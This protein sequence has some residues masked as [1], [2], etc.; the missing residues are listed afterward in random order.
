[1]DRR[2]NELPGVQSD[3][4]QRAASLTHQLP[5]ADGQMITAISPPRGTDR[6]NKRFD[7]GSQHSSSSA[8]MSD[9][10]DRPRNPPPQT[11]SDAFLAA[12]LGSGPIVPTAQVHAPLAANLWAGS[13]AGD[14]GA[15]P[16]VF[17][18]APIASSSAP[19][20]RRNLRYA[21]SNCA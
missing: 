3:R 9:Q 4:S 14:T 6:P 12:A 19:F 11:T 2:R 10:N 1:V 20:R 7:C 18:L 16:A 8:A 13:P 5:P 15:H 17:I 21:S